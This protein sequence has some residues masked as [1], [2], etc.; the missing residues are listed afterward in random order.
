MLRNVKHLRVVQEDGTR[1]FWIEI[2]SC[3]EKPQG[4]QN[5]RKEAPERGAADEGVAH[6]DEDVGTKQRQKEREGICTKYTDLRRVG[7][8][9]TQDTGMLNHCDARGKC[10][11]N[12]VVFRTHPGAD[13]AHLRGICFQGEI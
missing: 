12:G 4:H 3:E 10:S 8:D 11:C 1:S 7:T 5:L 2:V 9:P 6:G 13:L